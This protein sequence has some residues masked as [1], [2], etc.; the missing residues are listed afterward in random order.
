MNN[1][2]KITCRS[3]T[4]EIIFEK[5]E[6]GQ[7]VECSHCG[8]KNKILQEL[9]IEKFSWGFNFGAC[10]LT[11]LWLVFHKKIKFG[12]AVFFTKFFFDVLKVY[13]INII[14]IEV[15]IGILIMLYFG[16]NGNKI[17]WSVKH[18]NSLKELRQS[19]FNWNIAGILMGAITISSLTVYLFIM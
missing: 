4:K 8:I 15:L 19:Q 1:A 13:G 14:Y 7:K 6:Y 16:I 18:Y 17:S 9:T 10:F 5:I 2:Y 3:C 11:P 12:I